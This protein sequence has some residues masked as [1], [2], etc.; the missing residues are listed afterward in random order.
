MV[1]AMILAHLVG[2]YV[3]QWDRLARWKSLSLQG[4]MVHGAIILAVTW[5]F[6]LPFDASW[7]KGVLF[8]SVTHILIDAAQVYYKPPITPL[9]RF[10]IDQALHFAMIFIAL[11]AGGYLT[12]GSLGADLLASAVATPWLTA[13]TIYAFV[14]MPA[15]V[16][17]KFTVYAVVE[18]A[19][20]DFPAKPS[21]YVGITERVLI[22]TLVAFGQILLVPL[23]TLPRLIVAWPQAKQ[24]QLDRVYLA[25]FLASATLAIGTGLVLRMLP[26]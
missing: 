14:T 12:I 15:W 20:P 3:L 4:V 16:L 21:K 10:S 2:D 13:V 7:W 8:I 25:E 22:T 6:A 17:L 1:I 24:H 11:V 18:H 26:L 23:V 5:L 19:P 9:L